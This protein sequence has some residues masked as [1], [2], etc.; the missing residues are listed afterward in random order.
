MSDVTVSLKRE[1]NLKTKLYLPV[2]SHFKP[3]MLT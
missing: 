1:Q 3:Q 2:S